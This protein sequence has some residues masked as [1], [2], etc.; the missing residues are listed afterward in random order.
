[1]YVPPKRHRTHG[2]TAMQ[3][4]DAPGGWRQIRVRGNNYIIFGSGRC[5]RVV[6][7]TSVWPVRQCA[8]KNIPGAVKLRMSQYQACSRSRYRRIRRRKY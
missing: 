5:M 2:G 6:M 4:T 3:T 1:M 8:S 7:A